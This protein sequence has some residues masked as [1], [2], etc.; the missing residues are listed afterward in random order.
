MT[1]HEPGPDGPDDNALVRGESAERPPHQDR[2]SDRTATAWYRSAWA[3]AL[4][5]GLLALAAAVVTFAV[6][7]DL[8]TA[9]GALTGGAVV[10]IAIAVL[11]WRARRRRAQASSALRVIGGTADERE[12]R[13]A[14]EALAVVGLVAL[15]ASALAGAAALAGVD[16]Q[17]LLELLP[18]VLM[19]SGAI[20]FAVGARRG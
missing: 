9:M 2:T 5:A 11:G 13:L 4:V 10:L 18:W 14:L 3:G 6:R 8:E 7:V 16:P 20:T 12:Q 17:L 1:T 15:V 19:A